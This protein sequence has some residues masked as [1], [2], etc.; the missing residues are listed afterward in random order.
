MDN[1]KEAQRQTGIR[2]YLG[3]TIGPVRVTVIV[4]VSFSILLTLFLIFSKGKMAPYSF[5]AAA[6]L[7]G[8]LWVV[9][10]RATGARNRFERLVF[11]FA[12]AILLVTVFHQNHWD[13]TLG[14]YQNT[15][16]R[17]WNMYHYYIGS[18]YFNE[19]GYDQLYIQTVIADRENK[20]QRL[21][22]V[23]TIRD[24]ND[25]RKKK[26]KH[27][28]PEK[29][30]DKWTDKRWTEFKGDLAVFFPRAGKKT[31]KSILRDRG[32][33]PTPFWN[34]VGNAVSRSLDITKNNQLLFATS[35]DLALY[36][37]MIG[38]IIWAF[39]IEAALLLF[40]AFL[41]MP[42]NVSRIIGGYIQY[43]WMAAIVAGI[44]FV[45][46]KRPVGAAIF[47]GFATMARVFPL[48]ITMGLFAPGALKFI[49][50]RKIEKFYLVFAAV[51]VV[52]IIV[53]IIIGSFSA[54][55]FGGWMKWKSN[56]SVHNHEMTFG[57]GRIGLKHIFVH[58]LGEKLKWEGEDGRKG[59]FKKQKNIY[60]GAAFIYFLLFCL[61]IYFTR[62]NL[63]A[64]L[65]AMILIYILLV[66]SHYYWSILAL[67]VLWDKGKSA[68]GELP[69][70]KTLTTLSL[71]LSDE[72]APWTPALIPS[73]TAFFVPAGW[74]LYALKKP[75]PLAQYIRFDYLLGFSLLALMLSVIAAHFIKRG[76]DSVKGEEE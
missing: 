11:A 17:A 67:F 71:G 66:P 39:G 68:Y 8:G 59:I 31:W 73:L 48:I 15:R 35:I 24:L 45:K 65:A 10:R 7:L 28:V 3:V 44:C 51:F 25:Y 41:L 64:L 23:K 52:V 43:D 33:N 27:L 22:K 69:G 16:I 54:Y 13:R 57:E 56:I 63:N 70:L 20:N 50:S 38:C 5:G 46:K 62:N 40:L 9:L 26:L 32:Y 72:K 14:L 42:F 18:K 53:G 36:A 2:K 47:L 4:A 58:K 19:L 74:Y 6:C 12:V 61:T 34:T 30:S 75:V 21:T 1:E 76:F 49:K 60:Y 29:R 55:G 37:V